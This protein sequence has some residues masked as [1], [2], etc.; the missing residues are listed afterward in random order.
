VTLESPAFRRGEC[1]ENQAWHCWSEFNHDFQVH[2]PE[3]GIVFKDV[4]RF[5]KLC[6]AWVFDDDL[7]AIAL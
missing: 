2:S 5:R 1:Q 3:T 6:P 4:E 7:N